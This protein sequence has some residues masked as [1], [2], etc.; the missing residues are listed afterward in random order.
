MSVESGYFI[1]K[2]QIGINRVDTFASKG[3]GDLILFPRYDVLNRTTETR[4]TEIT[5]GLGLK[6]PLGMHDDSTVV[7]TNQTTGK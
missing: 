7:Y 1:N 6:I 3:F 4:R 2:T 5:L